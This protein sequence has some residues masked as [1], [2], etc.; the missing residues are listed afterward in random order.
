[1][2]LRGCAIA[3]TVAWLLVATVAVAQVPPAGGTVREPR[4]LAQQGGDAEPEPAP[5][6]PT[7]STQEP[8]EE[9]QLA[10]L[11]A[12]LTRY[13]SLQDAEL[14]RETA[15][16]SQALTRQRSDAARIRLAVLYTMSRTPQDDQRAL[17]LLETV[18]KGNPGSTSMKQLAA[19]LQVQIVERM[20][21]VREEQA[22]ANDAIQKL[23]ALRAMERSLLRDRVRGGG[24]AAGAGSGGN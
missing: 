1:M 4:V 19:V 21:A 6:V 10:A 8:T 13:G 7:P 2:T 14:R 5:G 15:A 22:K 11:V 3:C 20:R 9:Q 16:V 17:Q 12:D 23:E 24:G 18:S